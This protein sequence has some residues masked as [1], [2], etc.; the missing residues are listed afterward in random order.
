MSFF[1]RTELL[2]EDPIL[3]LPII[4]AADPHEKK[5]NIGVGA[6]KDEKGKPVVLS[7]VKKAEALVHAQ[8]L[9]KEYQ[10]IEGGAAFLQGTINLIYGNELSR[11]RLS[12]IQTIGGTSAL[13]IG[14]EF[15][16]KQGHPVMYLSDPSWPNH[17]QV[18]EKAGMT[19]QEY[20]YY[21]YLNNGL[22]FEAM[23]QAL[24]KM[25]PGSV[26][27]LHAGCHN[28]TGVD[29][30]REQWKIVSEIIKKRKVIPF[31]DLAYQGLGFSLDE[32]AWP[33]RYF[34]LQGHDILVASSYSKNFGLYGERV[35]ALSWYMPTKEIAA[36]L[37]SQFKQIVRGMY[38]S[39]PLHGGRL[40]ATVLESKALKD[41]WASELEQMRLRITE[42]RRQL[43][44]RLNAKKLS[45]NFNFME[46]QHGH[47]FFKRPEFG[48]CGAA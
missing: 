4:F 17:K 39:P 19:I 40:I 41:E 11:D 26:I 48:T 8:A 9:N 44:E 2:P 23:C 35:G 10:P 20:P 29:L 38:S 14:A 45:K 31:F 37:L 42:M 6:Y 3:S 18:F 7:A 28:P 47:V 15:L 34:A 22:K 36:R 25:P 30:M 16:V 43:M 33:I 12:A 27:L 46:K 13:R 24:E 32:D 21:D 1:E 5:V